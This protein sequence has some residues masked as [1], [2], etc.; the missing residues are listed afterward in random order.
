MMRQLNRS[1]YRFIKEKWG[2]FFLIILLFA[3]F[4]GGT[5]YAKKA[6]GVKT[7]KEIAPGLLEGYLAR[8]CCPTA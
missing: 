1:K 7:I 6:D 3:A 8:K 2:L 5:V 4:A